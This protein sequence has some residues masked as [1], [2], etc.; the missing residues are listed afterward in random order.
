MP[1]RLLN[2]P[3]AEAMG[4]RCGRLKIQEPKSAKLESKDSHLSSYFDTEFVTTSRKDFHEASGIV[5][6]SKFDC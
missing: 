5:A 3:M 1:P 4:V 6:L 2:E